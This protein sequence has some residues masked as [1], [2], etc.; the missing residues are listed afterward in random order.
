MTD[1]GSQRIPEGV[2][3]RLPAYLNILIQLRADGARTV[4]SA[5]LGE[6]TSVNPAQIRRDLTYFGSFGKRGVGYDISTLVERIQRILGSDHVHRLALVGAGN[7][8]SAIAGYNGLKQ[9]GFVVTAIFD[10]DP[11]KIGTRIGDIV[12]QDVAEIEDTLK[13]QQIRIGVVAVPPEAAQGVTDELAR[14]GVRVVLNY[15]P[16]IVRVPE[17]VTLHN[18]DPVQEL[19]HTLYYLSRRDGVARV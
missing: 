16:V 2:I 4:S 11:A 6:L 15:T 17:D 3:E 8:G 7:L 12:V 1:Q 18:T 5:R 19:L 9:H 10:A 13:K 14:A